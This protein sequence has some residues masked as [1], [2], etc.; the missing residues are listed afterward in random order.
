MT[1]PTEVKETLESTSSY[2]VSVI[3][4][5]LIGLMIVSY[6]IMN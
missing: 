3:T 5:L 2:L 4:V 6:L 1:R